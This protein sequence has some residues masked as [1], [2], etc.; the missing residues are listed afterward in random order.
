MG[1]ELLWVCAASEFKLLLIC[2][3]VKCV[4]LINS[5]SNDLNSKLSRLQKILTL[6]Q[7]RYKA[8]CTWVSQKKKNIGKFALSR[9]KS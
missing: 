1:G 7:S 6:I 4:P 8:T 9:R 5:I 2:I 3:G